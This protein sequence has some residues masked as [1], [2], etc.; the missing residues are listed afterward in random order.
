MESDTS[1]PA[2]KLPI[3]ALEHICRVEA[4]L[5]EPLEVG[6]GP[7][8]RRRVIAV[9][10]GTVR[11]ERINGTILP[12]G[13]DWQLVDSE[14]TAT[15]D[16]RYM[17]RTDD[18][19]LIVVATQG[20]RHGPPEVL[21][22]IAA[23]EVVAPDSYYFRVAVKLETGSPAYAWINHTVFVAI[24]ARLHAAVCYDLYALR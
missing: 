18:G 16:T 12:I 7:L 23:G 17:I 9:T 6:D 13:A 4:D 8:G 22:R 14:G 2:F 11:G 15:I 3:P 5:T 24:A 10:G 21:A 19:A 20:Y 1:A